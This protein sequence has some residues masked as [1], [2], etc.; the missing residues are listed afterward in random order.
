MRFGSAQVPCEAG[1]PSCVS[2]TLRNVC[3]IFQCPS[4]FSVRAPEAVAV[5]AM[6]AS[7][8]TCTELVDETCVT[9][10]VRQYRPICTSYKHVTP[11]GHLPE[12]SQSLCRTQLIFNLLYRGFA[13]RK[14]SAWA[15]ALENS[16]GLPI[17]N[18][19]YS[20]VQLCATGLRLRRAV[21][22]A[23]FCGHRFPHSILR[24]SH[25]QPNRVLIHCFRCP[26]LAVTIPK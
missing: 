17:A 24:P 16:C 26:S 23:P 21:P 12:L 14:A 2:T 9:W 3:K 7:G 5:A 13:T 4:S 15:G 18:R 11:S 6:T 8:A 20:R 19:R 1:S 10:P 22:S 25:H